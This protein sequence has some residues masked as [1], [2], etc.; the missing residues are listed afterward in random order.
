MTQSLLDLTA[1]NI[2]TFAP[3]KDDIAFTHSV[4]AQCFLPLRKLRGNAKRYE[5]QHG[6]ASLLI[7]AGDLIN[8]DTKMY[9]EQDVPYGAAARVAFAHIHNHVIR[10][11]SL[12]EAQ[13]VPMGES[14]RKFFKARRLKISGQNGKQI[15]KQIHNIAAAHISIGIWVENQTKQI[16]M[17]TLAEEIN[18]WVEKDEKQRSLW[19]PNMIL[20][21]RYVETIRERRVPLDIRALIQLYE[22]PRAMDVF[23]WLSY[24][25]PQ[26]KNKYGVFVPF[27]GKNGLHGVFGHSVK[28]KYKFKQLFVQSIQEVIALYPDARIAIEDQGLRLYHS[29]SPIPDE[30]A[31]SSSKSLFF[32]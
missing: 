32:Q 12:D 20:N 30:H 11:G 2:A 22:K 16:N 24:R 31:I 19:Q 29:P 14:L 18:F 17:P 15:V 28:D 13:D 27:F 9:E 21:R 25:L 5:I 7:K 4:F 3:T 6:N 10:A 1:S 8:P 23:T 26:I